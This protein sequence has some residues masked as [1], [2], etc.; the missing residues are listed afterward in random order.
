M[1]MIGEITMKK[2]NIDPDFE[3]LT[4]PFTQ[5]ETE[6]LEISL[7]ENG[8]ME[9]IIGWKGMILDGHKRYRIC[10]YEEIE[11]DYVEID[12]ISKEEAIVW[13][14]RNRLSTL[15]SK[16]VAYRY[17]VGIW[18]TYNTINH[19]RSITG[20]RRYREGKPY[21]S[22]DSIIEMTGRHRTSIRSDTALSNAMNE[23]DQK[24]HILF[25]LL[26][27]SK[28][29]YPTSLLQNMGKWSIRKLREERRK[30]TSEIDSQSQ[31]T[32]KE[33]K[34]S[35]RQ[36]SKEPEVQLRVG[37]KDMPQYDPDMELRGLALTIPTWANAI[38]RAQTKTDMTLISDEMRSQ[39]LETLR[40]FIQQIEQMMEALEL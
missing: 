6:A 26:M 16:T 22:Y 15:S 28:Q 21:C 1:E 40:R 4:V 38:E 20:H 19:K 37:I 23:I 7:L 27:G 12:A 25:K 17:L 29:K 3:K 2:L 5:E 18:Y 8:C 10:S 11:F 14:C 36:M 13:A 33:R 30:L 31:I 9:P 35:E 34:L 39:M 24:D 32:H